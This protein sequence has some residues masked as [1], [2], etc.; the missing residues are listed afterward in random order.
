MNAIIEE[1]LALPPG[2]P[3]HLADR[4]TARFY[5]AFMNAH[6]ELEFLP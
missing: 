2:H 3:R 5:Y 6:G 1:R 4:S